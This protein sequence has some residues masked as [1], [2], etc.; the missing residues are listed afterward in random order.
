MEVDLKLYIKAI[1]ETSEPDGVM[2][3][4]TERLYFKDVEKK[5]LCEFFSLYNY[6]QD[7]L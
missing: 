2:P 1:D 6:N 3:C 4:G 5:E 7:L